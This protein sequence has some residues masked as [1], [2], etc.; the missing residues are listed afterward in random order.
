MKVN[1][2]DIGKEGCGWEYSKR[3]NILLR[4]ILISSHTKHA[5][6]IVALAA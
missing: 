5:F 1:L 3:M 4:V 6:G 2:I